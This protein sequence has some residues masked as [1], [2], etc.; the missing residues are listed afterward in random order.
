V[1]KVESSS[2]GWTGKT[3]RVDLVSREVTIVSLFDIITI[4]VLRKIY[5]YG[6]LLQR[7]F[8]FSG[9]E[10]FVFLEYIDF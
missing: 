8:S 7:I 4:K 9:Q 2:G 6:T 1:T 3:A 10:K 5:F